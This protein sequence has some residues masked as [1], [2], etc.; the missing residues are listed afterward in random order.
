LAIAS[1]SIAA[2]G[3]EMEPASFFIPNPENKRCNALFAAVGKTLALA[4][5]FEEN[6]RTLHALPSL[7]ASALDS[8]AALDSFFQHLGQMKLIEHVRYLRSISNDE[9]C[10]FLDDARVARNEV[11][12]SFFLGFESWTLDPGIMMSGRDLDL[13]R[14]VAKLAIG[15]QITPLMI[16]VRNKELALAFHALDSLPALYESWVFADYEQGALPNAE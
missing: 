5:L 12:H 9:I 14:I 16:S 10:R 7:P 3:D 15:L 11:A 13:R 1:V 4:T 2:V 8:K 6:C